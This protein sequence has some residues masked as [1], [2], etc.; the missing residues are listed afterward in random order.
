MFLACGA[1]IFFLFRNEDRFNEIANAWLDRKLWQRFPECHRSRAKVALPLITKIAV[2]GVL[3][4][5]LGLPLAVAGALAEGTAANTVTA[6]L[7]LFFLFLPFLKAL[8][9]CGPG[10]SAAGS[11]T[12]FSRS[13]EP[14]KQRPCSASATMPLT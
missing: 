10:R 9:D 4:I 5:G 11:G 1:E 2:F 12:S 6:T 8:F 7:L 13:R 3:Y 14:P